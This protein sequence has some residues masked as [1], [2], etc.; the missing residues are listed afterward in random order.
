MNQVTVNAAPI[1]RR[2]ARGWARRV[3]VGMASLM[4]S[5]MTFAAGTAAA[6]G[7]D[8]TSLTT[9]V[10]FSTVITAILAVGAGMV[11]LALAV[12][13]VRKVVHFLK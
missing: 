9:A 4:V 2:A 10:D 8:L 12:M 3:G 5:G 6:A 7:P 1:S 11:G 13:G